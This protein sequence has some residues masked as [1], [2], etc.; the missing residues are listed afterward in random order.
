MVHSFRDRF[1]S[2]LGQGYNSMQ[3]LKKGLRQWTLAEEIW[4][5]AMRVRE[6]RFQEISNFLDRSELEIATRYFYVAP[7]FGSRENKT[8]GYQ[9]Q[10]PYNPPQEPQ[11]VSDVNHTKA[12]LIAGEDSAPIVSLVQSVC[13]LSLKVSMIRLACVPEGTTLDSPLVE[14]DPSIGQRGHRGLVIILSQQLL[15]LLV[16]ITT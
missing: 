14:R 11:N 16:A 12:S 10:Y 7:L 2:L 1:N 13:T 3:S 5:V 9:Y 15:M 4:V 8:R 6:M